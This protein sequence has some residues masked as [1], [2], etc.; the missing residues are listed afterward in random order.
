MERDKDII[1]KLYQ[2]KLM[3]LE[4][5]CIDIRNEKL[6]CVRAQKYDAACKLRDE[7]KDIMDLIERL[8]KM[9]KLNGMITNK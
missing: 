8:K 3:R 2:T 4:H 7:Q 1:L 9:M 5:K 6:N